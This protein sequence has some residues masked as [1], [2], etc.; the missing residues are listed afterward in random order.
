MLE[1]LRVP[2][3]GCGILSSSICMDKIYSKILFD[4]CNI[5]TAKS[6]N[7]IY[8]SKNRYLYYDK[9]FKITH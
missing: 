1:L 7:L 3:V 8:V 2:Y 5:K 6:I 4:R 9:N